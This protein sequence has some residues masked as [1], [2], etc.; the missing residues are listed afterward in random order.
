MAA[1]QY[2]KLAP[3]ESL[4][5]V[6]EMADGT[7]DMTGWTVVFNLLARDVDSTVV[8]TRSTPTDVVI[9]NAATPKTVTLNTISRGTLNLAGVQKGDFYNFEFL[10]TDSGA[11]K[12]LAQGAVELTKW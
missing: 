9:D 4:K 6:V 1:D 10:R 5:V 12:R 8:L 3:K 7:P 2:I 11:E